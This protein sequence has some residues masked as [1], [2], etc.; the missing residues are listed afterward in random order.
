MAK[1]IDEIFGADTFD[2]RDVIERIEELESLGSEGEDEIFTFEDE[3]DGEEYDA[4]VLFRD[5]NSDAEDFEFGI[6]FIADW[7]FEDYAREMAED[8]G[9]IDRDA[10]WPN[11]YIDWEAAADALKMDYTSVTVQGQDY[12]YR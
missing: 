2:S 12:W 10:N 11:S 7:H 1:T 8:I 3:N 6:N 5:Q 9:A 4:L